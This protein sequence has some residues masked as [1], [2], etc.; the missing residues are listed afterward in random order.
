[1][2]K[3]KITKEQEKALRKINETY[4]IEG[5]EQGNA[6][7]VIN[8]FI[9]SENWNC[10]GNWGSFHDFTPEQFA[11]LLCGWY[12]VEEEFKVGD[13]VY[14][15]TVGRYAPIDQRGVDDESVWVDDEEFNFFRKSQIRKATPEEIAQE[16]NRRKW[17]EIGRSVNEYRNGDIIESPDGVMGR[18]G[19][20]YDEDIV[21]VDLE[22]TPIVHE[23]HAKDLKL[24]CPVERRFDTNE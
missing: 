9:E 17:A 23:F 24:I 15:E 20:T 11:L 8:R 13:W 21:A 18:V 16:Q 4:G 19:D 22:K 3:L 2:D 1:M 10:K 6:H 12:T 5:G 14:N 7:K